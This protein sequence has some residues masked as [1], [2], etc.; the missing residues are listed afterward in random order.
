MSN[1]VVGMK[2][3]VSIS[4]A[5]A[6]RSLVSVIWNLPWYFETVPCALT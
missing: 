2:S 5:A 4:T 3:A 1:C 6:S